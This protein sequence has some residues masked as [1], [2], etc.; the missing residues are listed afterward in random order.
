MFSWKRWKQDGCCRG[1]VAA[2]LFQNGSGRDN[3]NPALDGF[4]AQAIEVDVLPL[5][6]GETSSARN[7]SGWIQVVNGLIVDA[8]DLAATPNLSDFSF[9][10]G[11]SSDPATW[12]PAPAPVDYKVQTFADGTRRMKFAWADGAIRNQW[13]QVTLGV[14]Q[15][16]GLDHSEVF[17]FGNQTSKAAAPLPVFTTPQLKEQKRGHCPF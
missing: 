8:A 10:V 1:G 3:F 2:Y 12:A 7:V 9:R 17:Y 16:T 5:G 13:L 11:T 4:D 14:S 15:R 6:A